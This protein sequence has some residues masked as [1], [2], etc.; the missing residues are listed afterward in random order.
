M[1]LL[2]G[3]TVKDMSNIALLLGR[4]ALVTLYLESAVGKFGGLVG[5]ADALAAKG[6]PATLLLAGLAAAGELAGALGVAFGLFTRVAALGLVV[7]TVFATVTFH[8]FWALEDPARA[9]QYMHFMKNLGLV[10]GLMIL[11][12]A[13]PGRFSL[14][15]WRSRRGG[16]QTT[17]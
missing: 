10:G 7:F 4:V 5:I 8:D 6:Y 12:A 11:S 14:D 15:A 2:R 3:V 1:L 13:G 17:A 9:E 16:P